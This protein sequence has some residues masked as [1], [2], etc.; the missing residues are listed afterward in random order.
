MCIQEDAPETRTTSQTRGSAETE[1]AK[2]VEIKTE[3]TSVKR[4]RR[5][6]TNKRL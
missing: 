5:E 2:T 3:V 1:I 4:S 6:Q